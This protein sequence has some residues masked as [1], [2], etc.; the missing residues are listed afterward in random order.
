MNLIVTFLIS[1]L[2]HGAN[3]TYVLWGL[4]HG[5]AQV[6]ENTFYRRKKPQE[7]G[8]YPLRW[9]LTIAVVCMAW[10]FFRANSISDAFYAVTHLIGRD[11]SRTL[12]DLALTV[13]AACKVAFMVAVLWAYDL[14]SRRCD[15]I[16]LL[17]KQKMP[18]RWIVYTVLAVSVIVL[19]IHNG[20][21]ASFIYFQF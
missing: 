7:C 16:L 2:W 3:W 5:V 6:I 17:R 1:G 14:F 12:P 21:D 15:L 4:I 20:A 13:R 10:I 8:C 9:L 18:V 11:F 19:K